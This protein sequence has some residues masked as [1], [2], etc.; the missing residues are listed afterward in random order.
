M[1]PIRRNIIV[2]LPMWQKERERVTEGGI[3]IPHLEGNFEHNA[4]H[5]K[6]VSVG[7]DCTLVKEGDEVFFSVLCIQQALQNAGR[8]KTRSHLY[9]GEGSIVPVIYFEQ[10]GKDYISMP[11][12]KVSF[13][14]TDQSGTW[15]NV[16]FTGV[17]LA[18][19]GKEIICMNGYHLVEDAYEKGEQVDVAGG[20]VNAIS[21][22]SGLLLVKTM[23]EMEK[24]K[25]FRVLHAP[26][27]S[28]T[29][30]GDIIYCMPHVDI[31]LE[32]DFNY[33]M[34]PKGCYYVEGQH[35]LAKEVA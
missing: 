8:D 10:D 33:N 5:G 16:I 12:N 11:E 24:R 15:E 20:K 31:K 23:E 1:K 21:T 19:R 4:T 28:D 6:V 22:E 13:E 7:N 35:I 30:T 29:Q 17:I 18:L 27:D 26:M 14:M 2:E 34:L 9:D 25:H 3:F 32:G